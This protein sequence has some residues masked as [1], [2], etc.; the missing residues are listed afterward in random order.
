MDKSDTKKRNFCYS[1]VLIFEELRDDDKIKIAEAEFRKVE[2]LDNEVRRKKLEYLVMAQLQGYVRYFLPYLAETKVEEFIS[3]TKKILEKYSA[4]SLEGENI[5][6]F[7]AHAALMINCHHAIKSEKKSKIKRLKILQINIK[8]LEKVLNDLE[9]IKYSKDNS[10]IGIDITD[11][12]WEKE[13]KESLQRNLSKQFEELKSYHQKLVNNINQRI[14]RPSAVQD[15]LS[16]VIAELFNDMFEMPTTTKDSTFY[17]LFKTIRKTAGLDSE[18]PDK[19][20][21]VA[22]NLI[23]TLNLDNSK[24]VSKLPSY[25]WGLC[26]YDWTDY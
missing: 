19:T 14:G 18:Y 3:D 4:Q 22:V 21:S 23:K 10:L 16:F 2:Q 6:N 26:S 8:R 5:N 11:N 15:N 17:E 24:D 25:F 1:E 20:I 9:N 13:L 12:N 7:I